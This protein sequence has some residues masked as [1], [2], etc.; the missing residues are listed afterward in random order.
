MKQL[1]TYDEL[2]K[3]RQIDKK[4]FFNLVA[5][6]GAVDVDFYMIEQIKRKGQKN[7]KKRKKR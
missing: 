3:L 4:E 1:P 2:M 7:T 5:L 6:L